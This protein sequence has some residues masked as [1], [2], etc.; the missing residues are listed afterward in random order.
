MKGVPRSREGSRVSACPE[1]GAHV[2]RGLTSHAGTSQYLPRRP[3]LTLAGSRAGA[4]VR[5]PGRCPSPPAPS[6]APQS[7]HTCVN[8]TVCKSRLGPSSLQ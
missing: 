4:Q 8:R 5:L 7:V 2:T 6:C 1:R 3:A